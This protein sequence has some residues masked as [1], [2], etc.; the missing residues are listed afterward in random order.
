MNDQIDL[1]EDV[2]GLGNL[3]LSPGNLWFVVVSKNCE[4]GFFFFPQVLL[5]LVLKQKF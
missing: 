1:A 5:S 4:K 3:A 2:V